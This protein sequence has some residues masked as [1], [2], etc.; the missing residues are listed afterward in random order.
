M[1]EAPKAAVE[2]SASLIVDLQKSSPSPKMDELKSVNDEL[3][4]DMI[5]IDTLSQEMAGR[6]TQAVDR[7]N[8]LNDVAAGLN[9]LV[10]GEAG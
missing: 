3:Q 2:K 5:V 8:E 4:S 6:M 9:K 7:V 10:T 1:S